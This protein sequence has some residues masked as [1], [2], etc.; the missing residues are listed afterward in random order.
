MGGRQSGLRL[1]NGRAS[2]KMAAWRP[3]MPNAD[4]LNAACQARDRAYA[5]YSKFRVGAALLAD[6]GRIYSGCNV[7]NASYGLTICAERSA[8]CAMVA[9]GA[10][11]IREI[12][13]IGDCEP[14]LP[15]CGAC[16]QV[17][18]EFATAQT[19]VHMC[20]RTGAAETVAFGDLL[21]HQ[22]E[23]A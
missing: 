20:S 6:D 17:I 2:S 9:A 13:V 11:K 14:V 12:L 10:A 3:S 22:F 1:T 5:P 15:P 7:E 4:L 19:M 16:R 23:L 21:P 18:A 8:V